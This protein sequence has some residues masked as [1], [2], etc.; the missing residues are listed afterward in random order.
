MNSVING[1]NRR[2]EREQKLEATARHYSI[3]QK[4]YKPEI[5]E[6]RKQGIQD[7]IKNQ[8]AL[9]RKNEIAEQQRKAEE[10]A[11]QQRKAEE[12]AKWKPYTEADKFAYTVI[13]KWEEND[14]FEKDRF[15]HAAFVLIWYVHPKY[16]ICLSGGI[17]RWGKDRNKLKPF[18]GRRDQDKKENRSMTASRE[19]REET[20]GIIN[21]QPDTINNLACVFVLKTNP[22]YLLEQRIDHNEFRRRLQE[23]HDPHYQEMKAIVH[24]PFKEFYELN[25]NDIPGNG[26]IVNDIS[27]RKTYVSAFFLHALRGFKLI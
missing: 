27:G 7:A 16:G 26:V 17:E 5:E 15:Y 3:I 4:L 1:L 6:I 19:L 24:I 14:I 25:I 23:Q 9:E 21:I 2:R 22:C 8:E 20:A 18:G 11:E 12:E 10:I 13:Q